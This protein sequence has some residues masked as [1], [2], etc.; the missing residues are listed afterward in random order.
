MCF[1]MLTGDGS[2]AICNRP[3]SFE[4]PLVSKKGFRPVT[5]SLEIGPSLQR[6]VPDTLGAFP[7]GDSSVIVFGSCGCVPVLADFFATEA[8][9]A[10]RYR[11]EFV[12]EVFEHELP[13]R[14]VVGLI[15][16]KHFP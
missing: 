10:T 14:C 15:G 2:G 1:V 9:A 6:Q 13:R 4:M 3:H 5:R 7:L 16:K 12:A 11:S 8:A